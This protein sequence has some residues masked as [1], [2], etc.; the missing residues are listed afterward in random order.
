MSTFIC[1]VCWTAAKKHRERFLEACEGERAVDFHSI[2][3]G[4]LLRCFIGTAPWA[5]VEPGC[6]NVF[7]KFGGARKNPF[8]PPQII[9]W[10]NKPLKAQSMQQEGTNSETMG[11][12]LQIQDVHNRRQTGWSKTVF[13]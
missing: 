13:L 9:F 12:L 11:L 7:L 8:G 10:P 5:M 3:C 6:V 2:F 1:V 4:A